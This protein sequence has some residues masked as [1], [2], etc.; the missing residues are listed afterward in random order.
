[1]RAF[2]RF[3]VASALAFFTL[4]PALAEDPQPGTPAGPESVVAFPTKLR[5]ASRSGNI[6][7]TWIDAQG[8]TNGSAVYRDV[9]PITAASLAEAQLL[10]KAGAAVQ[11]FTDSPPDTRE[12]F[13]V[14]L[15]LSASG[16][17]IPTFAAGKNASQVGVAVDVVAP[18]SAAS[19]PGGAA[20]APVAAAPATA[21]PPS[22]QPAIQPATQPVAAA[23][24]KPEAAKIAPAAVAT[25]TQTSP[26][27]PSAAAVP[28]K[29]ATPASATQTAAMTVDSLVA[30]TRGDS[31]IMTYK[32]VP[33]TRLVLYRG[34]SPLR[35]ASDLLDATLVA[36]FKDKDGAFADYPVPGVAYWYALV[37]EDDLKQ[38]RIS[39][40]AGRSATAAAVGLESKAG[41]VAASE[42]V[43]VL[44]TSRTPPLPVFLL[45]G[46]IGENGYSLPQ[47]DSP[48][49]PRAISAEAE[50]A[51]A[52]LLSMVPTAAPKRP[53]LAIL[54]EELS[55]P[56]GGEDYSL[57][58]IVTDKLGTKDW[59]AAAEQLRNYLSLNRSSAAIARAR[60]YLG[61]A[62]AFSGSYREAFFEFLLAR[63]KFPSETKS[64]IDYILFQMRSAS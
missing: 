48:P 39:L 3:A 63:E 28:L 6:L 47:D 45:E 50:K 9:K 16:E 1:M 19:P 61:Q 12:Y 59:K 29:P 53:N 17:P 36:A 55:A 40:V 42:I 13:Y 41:P 18:A 31:I 22:S 52:S 58:I 51:V 38:G 7:L 62:L 33:G 30:K 57:S 2:R 26:A 54:S 43:E 25:K 10:G 4:M 35:G 23:A 44:P 8:S 15:P 60:F 24:S 49:P 11:S 34:T 14:I 56:T 32:T 64:W 20:T 46:G 27:A 5:I 37:G 21:N